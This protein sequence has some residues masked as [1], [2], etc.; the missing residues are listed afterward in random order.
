MRFREVASRL[1]GFSTPIFGVS[2]EPSAS[3]VSIARRLLTFLE[4]RRVLYAPDE[5]EIQVHCVRSVFE[6]RRFMTDELSQL[7]DNSDL[8][9]GLR[10]MRAACRKFLGV[11]GEIAYDDDDDDDLYLRPLNPNSW[12][13]WAFNQA[14]GELRGVFGLHVAQISAK[15]GLDVE[16][17][18][19]QILPLDAAADGDDNEA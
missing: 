18:L 6:I 14:L 3:D 5:A 15:H 11:V 12:Q 7:P 4:D 10:A 19:A 1:T 17:A 16:E 13:S 8:E 2:W 9:E